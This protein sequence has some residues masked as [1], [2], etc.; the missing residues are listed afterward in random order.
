MNATAE[1]LKNV[2]RSQKK[3]NSKVRCTYPVKRAASFSEEEME[4][5]IKSFFQAANLIV[6]KVEKTHTERL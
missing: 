1:L 6:G 2:P 5:K 3:L 4:R